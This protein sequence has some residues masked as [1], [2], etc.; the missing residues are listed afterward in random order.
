MPF[1]KSFEDIDRIIK[2]AAT[3]CGLEYARGDLREQPGSVVSQ[4]VHDIRNAAIVVADISNGNPNV[5]YE[6]GI[7]H[8]LLGPERVVIITQPAPEPPYDVHEFRQLAYTHS[9]E[10]REKLRR[11]LP[12]YLRAAAE[13]R[14]DKE[15]WNVIRGRLSRTRLLVRDLRRLVESAGEGRLDG[16]VIR[17]VAGLGSLAISDHEPIDPEE[18]IEYAKN[19]I[20]ERNL[21]RKSLLLGAKM[22]SVLNP[23]RRFAQAMIPERLRVRYERLIG[24]LEGRSDI[25]DDEEAA[26]NDLAAIQNCEFALTPVPMPNQII[27]GELV[28]YEG[29]KRGGARGFHM[30]HCETDRESLRE[31]IEQFDRLFQESRREMQRAGDPDVAHQLRSF[32]QEI[33]SGQS[34]D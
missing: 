31:L 32:Y 3:E 2:D 33:V 4:I 14:A 7:A 19:L 17:M 20:D 10:G 27:I 26:R 24:L 21:V 29:M 9:E 34:T 8:Q 5:F 6:L 1:A 12:R 13:A 15:V 11:E 28:A 30:T 16:V 23:P 22:R 18:G 25:T